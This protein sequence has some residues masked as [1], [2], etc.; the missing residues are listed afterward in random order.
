M[1][2]ITAILLMFFAGFA[3]GDHEETCYEGPDRALDGTYLDANDQ[4]TGVPC[5][6]VEEWEEEGEE[7]REME[8]EMEKS[9]DAP[10]EEEKHDSP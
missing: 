7:E 2:T 8:A 5:N 1:K 9:M 10:L 4:P 6:T 3:F